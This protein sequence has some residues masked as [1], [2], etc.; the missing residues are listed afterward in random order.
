MINDNNTLIFL[1]SFNGGTFIQEQLDSIANQ[2]YQNWQLIVSDD[3]S[4]DNTF[5]LVQAFASTL[6]PNKV[7]FRKGPG[8]GF[9]Q[10]FLSMACDPQLSGS[11]Y[12]FSDQDDV[13]L[14]RKLE[15]A[16]S[17]LNR[18]E[19]QEIPALYCSR[20]TYVDA[21]LTEIGQSPHF[22]QAPHFRNALVQSI[23]GGN[24]MV[25]NNPLKKLLEAIGG[26]QVVSHDWWLYQLVTGVGGFVYYDETPWILYRQHPNALI[27]GNTSIMAKARRVRMVAEG[28]YKDMNLKSQMALKLAGAYLTKEASEI[29]ETFSDVRSNSV[30]RRC[31]AILQS[32]V[33]RQSFSGQLSLM[34]AAM[35]HKL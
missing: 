11:S 16:L 7:I 3:G 6:Q 1:G 34:L 15:R 33:Y 28:T 21:N 8:S 35:L 5:S 31:N 18:P 26:V 12:A 22:K 27:G 13:W 4:T 2:T 9:V 29:L 23:A 25:F 19:L 10:N 17:I 30:L 32:G 24:T 14:P 20:T